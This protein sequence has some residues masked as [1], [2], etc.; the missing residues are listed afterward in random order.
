MN[1]D[2]RAELNENG[3]KTGPVGRRRTAKAQMSLLRISP[4]ALLKTSEEDAFIV[5]AVTSCKQVWSKF[6]NFYAPKIS[7][8][9]FICFNADLKARLQSGPKYACSQISLHGERH[10]RSSV[11]CCFLSHA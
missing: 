5:D 3:A 2:G 7:W 8:R 11:R 9:D 10:R 4:G 6:V 1:G